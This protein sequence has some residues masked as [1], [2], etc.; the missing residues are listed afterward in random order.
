MSRTV[1]W[2]AFGGFYLSGLALVLV[3]FAGGIPFRVIVGL[4]ILVLIAGIGTKLAH[5]IAEADALAIG[6]AS[7]ANTFYDPR[8]VEEPLGRLDGH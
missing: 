1:M 4:L 3:V 7:T 8:D 2:A 5:E 6:P